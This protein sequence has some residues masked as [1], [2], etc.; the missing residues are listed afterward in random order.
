MCHM[1]YAAA[2][3]Q[4]GTAFFVDYCPYPNIDEVKKAVCK[5]LKVRN[6]MKAKE[7]V[8]HGKYQKLMGTVRPTIMPALCLLSTSLLVLPFKQ[9]VGSLHWFWA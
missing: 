2:R 1:C 5:F 8:G 3:L 7:M 6:D 9:H 4:G